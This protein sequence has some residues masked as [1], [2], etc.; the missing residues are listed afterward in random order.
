VSVANGNCK[1]LII[2]HDQK[3]NHHDHVV[4]L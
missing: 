4:D 1:H 3:D 2:D